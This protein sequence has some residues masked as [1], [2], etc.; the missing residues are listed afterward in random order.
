MLREKR[1]TVARPEAKKTVFILDDHPV[2]RVGIRELVEAQADL[3]VCGESAGEEGVLSTL[4]AQQP[5]MVILD[6]GLGEGS[7][8]ALLKKIVTMT[9]ETKVLVYSM[10]DPRVFAQRAIHAGALGYVDKSADPEEI[11]EGIRTVLGGK[12]YLCTLARETGEPYGR[13]EHEDRDPITALTDRELEVLSALGR[14]KGTREIATACN[15]SVKTVETHRDKLKRKLGIVST[16]ELVRFAVQW[17]L[18]TEQ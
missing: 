7:S 6:L 5:D 8:L 11:L 4:R 14:G 1:P 12:T 16:P 3:L 18:E 17:V 9:P 10:Q 15:L 13:A 2:T